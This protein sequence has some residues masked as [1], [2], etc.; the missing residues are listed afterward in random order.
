[1]SRLVEKLS[2][3]EERSI[4][5]VSIGQ[6]IAKFIKK[7]GIELSSF[8]SSL[9]QFDRLSQELPL[10][11]LLADDSPLD[12]IVA[13][14]ILHSLG[15]Q[16]DVVIN[17]IELL[18]ALHQKHYD[19]V[20]TD[21]QMPYMGGVEATRLICQQWSPATR[22]YIIALTSETEPN[23]CAQYLD[24]GMN[25]HIDKPLGVDKLIQALMNC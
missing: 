13:L 2:G 24:A 25:S 19:L 12:R 18:E 7:E 3:V 14:R 1:M 9:K 22:P 6:K 4:Q 5:K 20:I 17:G 10:R 15:Y 16:A 23:K 8:H 11:I 21:I